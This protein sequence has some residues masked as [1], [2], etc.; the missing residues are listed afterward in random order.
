MLKGRSVLLL[1]V[2]VGAGLQVAPAGSRRQTLPVSNEEPIPEVPLRPPNESS[3]PSGQLGDLIRLGRNIILN[4]PQYAAPYTG[5]ALTCNDC[6]L[7]GGTVALASPLAGVTTLFPAYSARAGRVIT[8]EDRL[9]ECFVRS[10][11]GKPLPDSSRDMIAMIAYMTWLSQGVPEGS[12]VAGRG[13]PR[14]KTPAHVDAKAGARLYAQ[15]CSSCHGAAGQGVPGMFPPLWGP[16]SA[17]D[18]AGISKA[19]KMAA[20]IKANMPPTAPGSLTVQ[21]AFDVAAF[22]DSHPRPRYNHAYDKF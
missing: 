16:R 4:T 20:F 13:L 9:N 12:T 8:I 3:I 10:Q 14:L 17:N 7:K 2:C 18:G 6:H 5:N 11:N 1:V 19:P 21:A 15:R 22:A